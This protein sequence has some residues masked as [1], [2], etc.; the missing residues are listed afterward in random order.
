MK[1][2]LIWHDCLLNDGK[3]SFWV[4][5][6]DEEVTHC[7]LPFVNGEKDEHLEEIERNR[8][9]SLINKNLNEQIFCNY[10]LISTDCTQIKSFD[11]V[12][13]YGGMWNAGNPF[14]EIDVVDFHSLDELQRI[15]NNLNFSKS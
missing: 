7:I 13:P 14:R 2:S 3:D 11:W 5:C 6:T 12:M 1:T 15:Y 9:H 8:G 10:F 4:E